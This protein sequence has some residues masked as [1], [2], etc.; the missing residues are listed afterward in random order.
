MKKKEIV[1]DP[2]TDSL[3]Q[4]FLKVSPVFG[5]FGCLSQYVSS[6]V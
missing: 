1:H 4:A 5:L 6:V 2:I 3:H